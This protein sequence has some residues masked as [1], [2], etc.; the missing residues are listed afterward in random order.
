MSAEQKANR[1]TDSN[2]EALEHIEGEMARGYDFGRKVEHG[3]DEVRETI[4]EKE[5]TLPARPISTHGRPCCGWIDALVVLAHEQERDRDEE[6][7]PRRD[8]K[9][10][11]KG[12]REAIAAEDGREGEADDAHRG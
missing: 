7:E 5:Q 9:R 3:K 8:E 12:G 6:G 11:R 1:H 2:V 10:A 4:A